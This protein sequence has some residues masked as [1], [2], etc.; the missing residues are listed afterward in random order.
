MSA[1]CILSLLWTLEQ[2]ELL[3]QQKYSEHTNVIMEVV[4]GAIHCSLY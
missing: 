1:Q 2:D 4:Y 3:E